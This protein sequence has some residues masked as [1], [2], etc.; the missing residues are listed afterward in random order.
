LAGGP[1]VF[2][3]GSNPVKSGLV[4]GINRPGGNVT[5]VSLFAGILE[6]NV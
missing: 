5:G 3:N 1:I 4:A 2:L 6:A